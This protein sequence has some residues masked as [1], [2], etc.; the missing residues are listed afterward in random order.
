[1]MKKLFETKNL[2][3]ILLFGAAAILTGCG[4]AISETKTPAATETKTASTD[5]KTAERGTSVG[6]IAPDFALDKVDGTRFDSKE[7]AGS[8]SVLVF[9]TAWCP[10]C[11]EEA[12]EINKL[13]A[14]FEPKGV[15]VVG[16]N[17]GESDA[18]VADGIKDFGIK[19][20]RR[21]R[22]RFNGCQKLPGG[23]HADHRFSRRQRHGAL[24][25]Q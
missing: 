11:K 4:A 25:R 8:P 13:A 21:Q 1:M 6:Q 7:L 12:P 23:R 22:Q 18:R 19:S 5:P 24:L 9:W 2:S 14:A 20:R 15:K 17:I 16:I 3:L 10:V